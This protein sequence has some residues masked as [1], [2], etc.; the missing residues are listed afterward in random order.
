[1]HG[2]I[3]DL[4]KQWPAWTRMGSGFVDK[5]GSIY[6]LTLGMII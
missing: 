6:S 2:I 5:E 4:M 1:M 3:I